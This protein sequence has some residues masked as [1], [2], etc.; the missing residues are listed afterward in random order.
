[1]YL[2]INLLKIGEQN[3]YIEQK[4]GGHPPPPPPPVSPA[5]YENATAT[6]ADVMYYPVPSSTY[7]DSANIQYTFASTMRRNS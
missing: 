2:T 4:S 5:L 3:I 6:I 7:I 1:M